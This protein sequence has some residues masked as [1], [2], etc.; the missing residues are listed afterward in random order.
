MGDVFCTNYSLDLHRDLEVR[1]LLLPRLYG[2]I[3]RY[4]HQCHRYRIWSYHCCNPSHGHDPVYGFV[5]DPPWKQVWHGYHYFH[6]LCR[7]GIFYL[8]ACQDVPTNTPRFLP[9][10]AKEPHQFCR[11]HHCSDCSHN[12]KCVGLHGQLRQ[13]IEATCY[14]A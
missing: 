10:S 13:R 4:R 14:E 9:T 2:S 7:T 5:L 1:F 8:Q 11:H 6:V 3:P 12:H